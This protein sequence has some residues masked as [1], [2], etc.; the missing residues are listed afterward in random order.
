M[1]IYRECKWWHVLCFL[2]LLICL[3]RATAQSSGISLLS[4]PLNAPVQDLSDSST[5][6]TPEELFREF[7]RKFAKQYASSE[8]RSRRLAI[9]TENLAEIARRQAQDSNAFHSHLTPFADWSVEE[10][11]ARNILKSADTTMLS[12]VV[13]HEELDIS[14]LPSSFDWRDKG[15][16]NEVKDQ[17]HCGSCW[18]FAAV[19]NIEGAAFVHGIFNGTNGTTKQLLSLSEQELVDCSTTFNSGCDGGNSGEAFSDMIDKQIG[20]EEDYDYPYHHSV[21][22]CQINKTREQVF[23]GGWKKIKPDED[24]IAAALI[25]YAPLAISIN[26]TLL[27][28]YHH[29]ILTPTEETCNPKKKDH[30]VNIVGFGT[31]AGVDYWTVRNSWNHLWGEKG[32][33]R[34]IRGR[35]ACGLKGYVVTVTKTSQVPVPWEPHHHPHAPGIGIPWEIVLMV[36]AF[37]CATI[38]VLG[39][40]VKAVKCCCGRRA[41][42][43]LPIRVVQAP[44]ARQV[45]PQA[46]ALVA[47]H[48]R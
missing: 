38:I 25:Q 32:Y 43:P 16:V 9:F 18:A 13:E 47:Q 30:G 22:K 24:Q 12:R 36:A 4:V 21:G 20:L 44:L 19:C 46:T 7:E 40:L 29:G 35:N 26:A 15:A 1:L 34:I 23:V 37:V 28:F 27:Q 42:T 10:F 39:C 11:A 41:P 45:Q 2:T 3:G 48:V 6:K 14:S 33:F 8:E 5:A 31:D 17:G